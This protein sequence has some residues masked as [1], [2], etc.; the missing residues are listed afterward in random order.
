MCACEG[1]RLLER[2]LE[3]HRKV[4]DHVEVYDGHQ[5]GNQPDA[6]TVA[7]LQ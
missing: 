4:V 7:L 2:D 5:A 6:E 1:Y 3:E